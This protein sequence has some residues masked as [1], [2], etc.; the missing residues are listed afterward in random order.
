MID[1]MRLGSSVEWHCCVGILSLEHF[2]PLHQ[3]E[4][5]VYNYDMEIVASSHK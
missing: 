4:H 3:I 5:K 2:A 1:R